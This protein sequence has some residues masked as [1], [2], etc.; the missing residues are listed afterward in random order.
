MNKILWIS[1]GILV[2]AVGVVF[3]LSKTETPEDNGAV[4]GDTITQEVLDQAEVER[5]VMEF[6]SNMHLV[7]LSEPEEE[8]AVAID[9]AYSA[10]VIPELLS[11]WKENP[12]SAPGRA[13]LSPWPDRIEIYSTTKNPDDTYTVQGNVIEITDDE[14]ATSDAA[15][16]YQ[17]AFGLE[18]QGETWLINSFEEGVY[19]GEKL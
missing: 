15:A 10:Y 6:G 11:L 17:V 8:V 3:F 7:L 18:R 12:G 19:V 2:L 13:T 14:V 5:V 4:E 1:L 16:I 9:T